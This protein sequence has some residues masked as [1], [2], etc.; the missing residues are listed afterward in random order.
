MNK[1][2]TNVLQQP[3][4]AHCNSCKDPHSYHGLY[5][6]ECTN[7]SCKNFSKFHTKSVNEYIEY[8]DKLAKE[9]EERNKKAAIKTYV[10]TSYKATVDEGDLLEED[11]ETQRL[12]Y[13]MYTIPNAND[14]D[15]FRLDLINAYDPDGFYTSC[16]DND[17]SDDPSDN[18]PI[19]AVIYDD[20]Y[21]NMF[22]PFKF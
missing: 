20:D 4:N 6:C 21:A 16:L 22:G 15:D 7:S 19:S 14:P 11:N 5:S 10:P 3:W 2:K 12:T 17:P 1:K 8:L 9:A 18:Q 13:G